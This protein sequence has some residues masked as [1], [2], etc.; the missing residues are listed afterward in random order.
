[1]SKTYP[2]SADKHAHDIE[3]VKNRAY[4]TLHSMEIGEIP[5]D[6][7]LYKKLEER[8]D[9]MSNLL[10]Q[11][12]NS[13]PDGK[14]AYLTGPQIGIAK[15]AVASAAA[16]RGSMSQTACNCGR[17]ADKIDSIGQKL[18][19]S[20]V[21]DKNGNWGTQYMMGVID[22][23][24]CAHTTMFGVNDLKYCPWCGDDLPMLHV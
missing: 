13:S 14:M 16:M 7:E 15:E 3:F 10:D 11:I 2:F 21:M 5:M 18:C 24:G 12:L 1:M 22:N 9:V 17:V 19:P 4:N 6:K 8:Y 20:K 23:W